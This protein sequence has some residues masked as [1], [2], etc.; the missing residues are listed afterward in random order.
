MADAIKAEVVRQRGP[1][2]GKTSY[3]RYFKS[4]E[5]KAKALS[6]NDSFLKTFLGGLVKGVAEGA[7]KKK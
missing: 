4:L 6:N 2:K 5:E 1:N 3:T 7:L